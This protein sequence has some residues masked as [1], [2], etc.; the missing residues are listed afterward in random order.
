MVRNYVRKRVKKQWQKN[1]M[2]LALK[3]VVNEGSSVRRAASKHE[4]PHQILSSKL[5]QYRLKPDLGID[6][7]ASSKPSLC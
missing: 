2:I 6:E 3:E 5:Q 4:V 1:N 7:I